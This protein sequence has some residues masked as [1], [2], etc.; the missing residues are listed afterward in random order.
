M[1]KVLE[2]LIV[3]NTLIVCIMQ[4][5]RN[6]TIMFCEYLTEWTISVVYPRLTV[7][8]AILMAEKTL[9]IHH[10]FVLCCLE[11]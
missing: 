3:L 8:V 2:Q 5:K 7:T 10:F 4:N 11:K 6:K 1:D 9:I